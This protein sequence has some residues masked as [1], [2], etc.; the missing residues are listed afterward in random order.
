MIRHLHPEPVAPK[1]VVIL[2]GSGFIGRHLLAHLQGLG[3]AAV[4]LSSADID[5]CA[6]T[7]AEQL[8]AMLRPEDALVFASCLTPDKG[9]NIRT[10]MRNLA[11]GEQVCAAMERAPC[12]HLVYLSSDAVYS[13]DDA[14]VR[15]DS[16]CE[17]TSFYGLCHLMRE[18]MVRA[19][20]ELHHIPWLIVRPTLVYGIDDTH[21]SYGPN[22]FARQAHDTGVIKLFGNGE[23]KRDHIWIGDAARL[24]G[25]C[26]RHRSSGILNLATG[27]S[28]SFLEAAQLCVANCGPEVV[29]ERLPRSGPIWH[30]HFDISVLA[31]AFPGFAF[32]S[33]SAGLAR[34][35]FA[36]PSAAA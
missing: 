7:A 26:L 9:K 14:F 6:P 22:R 27:V 36:E 23:E 18:R 28:N 17:P 20:G 8:T 24:L 11:M 31:R 32:T 12:A 3:I 33:L 30:R 4:G 10:A 19:T 2:G 25:L 35:Y 15:E 13:D 29:L 5:L 1:R 21:N 16:R 34:E